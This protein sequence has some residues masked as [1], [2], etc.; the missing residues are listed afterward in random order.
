MLENTTYRS[1]MIIGEAALRL[2][3]DSFG[4]AGA[5]TDSAAIDR[6]KK[7]YLWLNDENK[8]YPR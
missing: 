8:A 4:E 2:A 5:P 1:D 6:A 7:F 3:V